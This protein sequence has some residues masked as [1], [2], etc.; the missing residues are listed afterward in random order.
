MRVKMKSTAASTA[1]AMQKECYFELEEE[2]AQ[3]LIDGGFAV[4]SPEEDESAVVKEDEEDGVKEARQPK[5]KPKPR[6]TKGKRLA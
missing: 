2:W 5:K 6:L 3:E 4:E 1:G